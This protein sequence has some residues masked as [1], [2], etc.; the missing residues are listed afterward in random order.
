MRYNIA[1]LG[2]TVPFVC[3]PSGSVGDSLVLPPS[4]SSTALWSGLLLQL[5][6]N[7]T[8]KTK[9]RLICII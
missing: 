2:Y 1:G 9:Y 3:Y 8:H 4:P 7:V 6:I 5:K